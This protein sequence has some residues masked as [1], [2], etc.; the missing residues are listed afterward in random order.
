[1]VSV[2]NILGS[3]YNKISILKLK[4]L[5]TEFACITLLKNYRENKLVL[6]F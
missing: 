3:T 5:L 2:I 1:M 6:E 4:L